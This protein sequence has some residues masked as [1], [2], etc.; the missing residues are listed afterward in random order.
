MT[1]PNCL[2]LADGQLKTIGLASSVFY[3]FS[4]EIHGSCYVNSPPLSAVSQDFQS[5]RLMC[6][7]GSRRSC[8]QKEQ[9]KNDF[10]SK[11]SMRAGCQAGTALLPTGGASSSGPG[12]CEIP[13]AREG[14]LEWCWAVAQALHSTWLSLKG[15]SAISVYRL[16]RITCWMY[17]R[18][19]SFFSSHK[20][21][22]C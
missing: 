6:I 14:P 22:K 1:F 21:K 10:S 17:L 4:S 13:K 7:N 12:H 8:S 20:I 16:R 3:L 18:P 5:I 19:F 11:P 2:L 9:L 15:P